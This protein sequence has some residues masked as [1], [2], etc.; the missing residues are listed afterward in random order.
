M[1]SS[2]VLQALPYV[3]LLNFIT[4]SLLDTNFEAT[5]FTDPPPH[6]FITSSLKFD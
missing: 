5:Y 1:C 4:S 6:P 3:I 2:D